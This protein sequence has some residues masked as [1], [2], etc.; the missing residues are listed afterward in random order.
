[1]YYIRKAIQPVIFY[2]NSLKGVVGSI[3][4]R[5]CRLHVCVCVCVC[6]FYQYIL[7]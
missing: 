7:P 3:V 6:V 4:K 1:M 5:K 2:C